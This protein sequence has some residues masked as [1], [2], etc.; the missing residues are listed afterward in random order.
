[1]KKFVIILLCCVCIS[2]LFAEI[3]KENSSDYYY[4]NLSLERVY[5]SSQGYILQYRK[6]VS[7]IATFGVP[8]EWFTAAA[9]KAEIIIL[10]RGRNGPTVTVFY[11]DGEFSHLRLYVHRSKAHQTWGNVPQGADVSKYFKDQDSI[12]IEF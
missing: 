4:V 9:S 12:K 7:G 11:K 5:P 1:M 3:S 10:P 6:G 8:N 2:P